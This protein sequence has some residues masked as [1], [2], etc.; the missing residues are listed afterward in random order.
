MATE[1]NLCA[2]MDC[3]QNLLNNFQNW[4]PMTVVAR[5]FLLFQLI[6][7]YPLIT[8]MLRSQF[9]MAVTGDVYPGLPH[10]LAFNFVTVTVCILFAIFLPSIGTIIRYITS[11]HSV[12]SSIYYV[13]ISCMVQ[14]KTCDLNIVSRSYT[15]WRCV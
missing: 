7:V 2:L 5:V 13:C 1:L 3:S 6:T 14:G 11:F 10:V 12:L 9:F 8:F 4:D 15:E